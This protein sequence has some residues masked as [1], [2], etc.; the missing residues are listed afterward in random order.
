MKIP[1]FVRSDNNS[2]VAESTGH[3]D[4]GCPFCFV[5]GMHLNLRYS[6]K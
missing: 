6:V 1:R 4:K 5:N 2:I 3:P